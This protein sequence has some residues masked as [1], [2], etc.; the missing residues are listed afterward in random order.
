M[1]AAREDAD[2]ETSSEEYARRFAG[3]VGAFLLECQ[4]QAS[5]DLLASFRGAGILDVGGGHGQLA[6]P[7]ADAGHPVTVFGSDPRCRQRVSAL[8]DSGRARFE[9]GELLR[10]PYADQ[11]YEVVLSYR[12]LPHVGRWTELIGELCRVA[13]RAVIVDYPTLRSFNLVGR[14]LFAAKKVVEGNTRPFRVF[15]DPEIAAAFAARGFRTTGRRGQFFFPMALHRAL[16]LAPLSR[17]LEGLAAAVGLVAA[18]G[19]PV[20]LRQER[21][22]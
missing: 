12:L 21:R 4:T 9:S 14:S 16:G 7:L 1:A 8:V 6:G 3:P 11:A 18:F 20:I 19:S 2:L 10:L 5:L 17:A 15:R 22:G 13:R